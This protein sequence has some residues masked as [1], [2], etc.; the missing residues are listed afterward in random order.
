VIGKNRGWSAGSL[1]SASRSLLY[2]LP[3]AL[4]SVAAA[5]LGLGL[6]NRFEV[7]PWLVVAGSVLL[8]DLVIYFQHRAFHAVPL[9]WRLHR[10]HHADVDL[11]ATTGV[12]FHPLEAL[13]SALIKMIAVALIGAPL[14]A[15]IVFELILSTTSL[16]N[17][18]N[19]NIP[20]AVDRRLRWLLVTPDMH[21]VHHSVD[22]AELNRNF[23]FNLPWWDRLF[24]TYLDQPKAGHQAMQIGLER[25]RSAADQRLPRLLVQPFR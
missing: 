10:M 25:F 6:F 22:P 2:F 11:D 21:R 4:V 15:V 8:L 14:L 20:R 12:R 1:I 16:F 19:V 7:A 23:G 24:G 3:I 9:F 17:H 5:E 13:T 18:G